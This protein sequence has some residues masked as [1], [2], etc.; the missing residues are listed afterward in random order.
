MHKRV[1]HSDMTIC[2]LEV[3]WREEELDSE[4]FFASLFS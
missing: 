1:I 4:S 2:G 3:K